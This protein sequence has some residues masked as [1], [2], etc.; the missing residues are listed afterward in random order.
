MNTYKIYIYFFIILHIYESKFH[1]I[2][3][4]IISNFKT[5]C[6]TKSIKTING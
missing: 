5:V 3:S 1:K 6:D 2:T 4:V